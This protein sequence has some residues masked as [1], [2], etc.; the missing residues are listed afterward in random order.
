MKIKSVSIANFRGIKRLEAPVELGALGFFIGDNGTGKTSLLEAMNFCLSSGYVASRLDVNDF[1]NGGDEPIEIVVEFQSPLTAKLPDGFTSQDVAC[2]KVILRAK[3][4]DRAAPGKA[5]SDLVTTS[6][7]LVP[8]EPRGEKGWSKLRKN[9]TTFHFDERLLLPGNV[10]VDLP[11]V[12]YFSKTRVR[13]LSK[14]FNSSLSSI[15]D[16][17]NWRFD[18]GQRRKA[19]GDHFKHHRRALQ[20]RIFAETD[21][22]TL[23]KTIGAANDILAKLGVPPV[24][25]SLLKT[26]NPYDNAE[27]VFPFDG[28]EL[29]AEHGG[30]GIEMLL[31]LA[32]LEAMAVLSK[33][34]LIILVDEPELHLHPK[35]QAKL[36]EH[37]AELS[38]RVQ[39]VAS[40][41]SP[42]LF[43]NAFRNPNAKLQ[44]TK[45]Y[46][47]A[48]RVEDA[49]SAGFGYL[50]WSPSWGEI[51]YLAYD[52]PTVEFHDD[53]YCS[54][55]DRFRSSPV[56]KTS[57]ADFDQWLVDQGH[58]REIR[59]VDAN[60][61][62]REE[63][64]MTYVRN[65]IHH[66]EN[67]HRPEHSE[68]QLAE[69]IKR[70][71]QLIRP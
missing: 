30:S 47:G 43:K 29:P 45:Q 31:S 49:H 1:Y 53:L 14:G 71:C 11:R 16:D 26:L 35:L 59:W 10:E 32:L 60:G 58:P 65:R 54:L 8:V 4:R 15:I 13:Q 67:R 42:L 7:H 23:K 9:G 41:H 69:S 62:Q 66:P 18:R 38:D 17:L 70:M 55:E 44:I 51:S 22:D 19:E 3:K 27:V 6:H 36:V 56:K 57:Q 24:E 63:T 39:I 40:T 28:F 21:G 61:A 52:L 25:V 64:L 33:E 50:Q 68:E 5:F 48:V 34:K 37:L 20:D 12:F 2:D 46:Q